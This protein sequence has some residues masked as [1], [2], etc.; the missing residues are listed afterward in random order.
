[1]GIVG[2]MSGIGLS[3]VALAAGA[4]YW[5][6][7]S[8]MREEKEWLSTLRGPKDLD[9]QLLQNKKNELNKK[10]MCVV[11]GA[12]VAGVTSAYEMGKL[13]YEVVILDKAQSICA[14]CSKAP[15]GGMQK[16]NPTVD[17]ALWI[18]AGKSLFSQLTCDATSYEDFPF[19]RIGWWNTITDPHFVRW[20]AD[21]TFASF[22]SSATKQDYTSKHMLDFTVWSVDV[23][24]DLMKNQFNG[25]LGASAGLVHTGAMKLLYGEDALK[26]AKVS[27]KWC[28]YDAEP[29]RI[30]EKDDLLKLEPW[31]ATLDQ[32]LAVPLSGALF[33]T[34]ASS[35]SCE[36]LTVDLARICQQEYGM[37]FEGNAA[38]TGFQESKGH[39][40]AIQ[41]SRGSLEVPP[42][43]PVIVA[44]GSWTP[45]ILRKLCLYC[46]LYPLK[47]YNL[48][49]DLNTQMDGEVDSRYTDDQLPKRIVADS[50]MYT[51][52]FVDT[53]RVATIGEFNGWNTFPDPMI[54]ADVRRQ[55]RLFMPDLAG[56]F[57]T[58]GKVIC[59]LR[60]FTS[61]GM[62]FIGQTDDVHN[63]YVN[64][65]PGFNGW[66]CALGS[67]KV[68]AA[69]V[70]GDQSILPGTFDPSVFKPGA[71][72][73]RS[74][75]FCS[76]A[77][78]FSSA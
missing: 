15:A 32:A 56:V 31:L 77:D 75:F 23:F 7:R 78:R 44:A 2:R 66:K 5:Q 58:H 35:A 70:T 12:G 57:N 3:T 52:R 54:E 17:S 65:G 26:A 37:K 39:I 74:P 38:V 9:P 13:G 40:V 4:K 8:R 21:F 19:F 43:V 30:I 10:K 22:M 67:A 42:E 47:G 49:V 64:T 16:M 59:G 68:L 72:V 24:K 29:S 61:N 73:T 1:M 69:A 51:T 20:F 34:T 63:L 55:T 45:I 36:D 60:P 71:K 46:S 27:A 50:Y 6:T 33:Q 48:M 25:K 28:A 53:I 14:E 62:L 41:T 18:E 76:I 11:V